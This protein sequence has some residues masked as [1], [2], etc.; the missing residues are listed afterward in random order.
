MTR[1]ALFIYDHRHAL[2]RW[3][4]GFLMFLV[5]IGVQVAPGFWR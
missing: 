3:C 5:L 1:I 4:V 2:D